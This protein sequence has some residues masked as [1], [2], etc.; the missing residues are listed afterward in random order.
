MEVAMER[1]ASSRPVPVLLVTGVLGAGKTTLINGI[2]RGWGTGAGNGSGNRTLAAI[3]NDFGAI[4]VDEAILSASGQAVIGLKNGCICCSLQG[5]LLRTLRTVLSHTPTVDGI[6]IEASGV[7]DPRGIVAAL[8]DPVL[9]DAVRLDAVVTVVD[10][11]EHDPADPL[12]RTQVDAADFIV[13]SKADCVSDKSLLGTETLLRAMRKEMVFAV[14]GA[15]DIPFDILFANLR[16]RS[17]AEQET[18][19]PHHGD[20]RFVHLEWSSDSPISFPAFQGAIQSFAAQLARAKG[21]LT[22]RER[23]GE[24]FLFQLVGQRASLSPA[25]EA[26]SGTQL[27]FIGRADRFDTTLAKLVLDSLRQG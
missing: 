12:W 13:L 19:H 15:D 8:Y 5:D 18:G 22:V 11:Q 16:E 14:R 10:A 9:G 23:P 27:V 20:E 17:T 21:F 1:D 7:S 3:V 6:V 2:L 26:G 24:R 25:V 4:N